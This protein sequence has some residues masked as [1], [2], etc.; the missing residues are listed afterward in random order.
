LLHLGKKTFIMQHTTL[1][2]AL[3]LS[4]LAATHGCA[5]TTA[6]AP[7]TPAVADSK[8]ALFVNLTRGKSDLHAASMGLT[9]AKTAAEHGLQVVVLLNVEAAGLADRHLGA[10]VRFADFPPVAELLKDII[11]H[12]GSVYVCA[13]CAAAMKLT[14]EDVAP[15]IVL[16]EG[17][18]V[19]KAL[20]PGMVGISY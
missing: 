11:A 5:P 7:A 13:H 8:P 12:G 19:L 10:D 3:S 17:G 18:D 20:H 1:S 9:L 15:G 16:S 6:A 14:R 4:I 2:L